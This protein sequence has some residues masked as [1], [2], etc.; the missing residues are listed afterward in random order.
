MIADREVFRFAILELCTEH[1][2]TKIGIFG[3][4]FK[5][6]VDGRI[7]KVPDG[8]LAIMGPD[9]PMSRRPTGVT[10]LVAKDKYAPQYL[11]LLNTRSLWRCAL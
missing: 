1:F 5:K 11:L 10:L 3:S 7:M 8:Y 6:S 9:Y 2:P 4:Q